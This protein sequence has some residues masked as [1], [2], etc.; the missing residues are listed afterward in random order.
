[1]QVENPH[2]R[3]REKR[4]SDVTFIQ[5]TRLALV[6]VT[7]MSITGNDWSARAGARKIDPTSHFAPQVKGGVCHLWLDGS[8][9]SLGRLSGKRLHAIGWH[10][11]HSSF[12]SYQPRTR[13]PAASPLFQLLLDP[14][15]FSLPLFTTASQLL[16]I[17]HPLVPVLHAGPQLSP[18]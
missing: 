11:C 3:E 7:C 14:C 2:S 18:I 12:T 13:Y 16:P 5:G 8:T 6:L 4:F 9:R 17:G 1:M 15:S 10:N